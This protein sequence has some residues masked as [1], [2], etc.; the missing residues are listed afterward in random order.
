M[1]LNYRGCAVCDSTWGNLYEEVEG[2][3]MF[4]CCSVC[5]VQFRE[6]VA[7]IRKE[8]GWGRIDA[9]A[10]TGDRRGRTCTARG[11]DATFRCFVAFNPEGRIRQFLPLPV[12]R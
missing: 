3:R 10:I 7:R 8:A 9:L 6:L 4:F 2:Q 1:D 5:A 11:G 12:E